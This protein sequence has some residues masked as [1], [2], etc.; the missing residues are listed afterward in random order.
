LRKY[1]LDELPQFANV[2]K[3]DMSI[4]GPR[5]HAI[6]YNDM[7]SDMVEEIKLRHRVKPGI[8]G[9]AQVHGLRGDVFDFEE[10]KLRTKKRIDFDNWYIEN[11]SI[12]LDIQIIIE[13]VWQIV[14]GRNLGT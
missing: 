10:N 13:T 4:V 5:P 11:W 2:L 7:Y 6:N 3:G 8:S 9:W 1:S 14:S 12:K